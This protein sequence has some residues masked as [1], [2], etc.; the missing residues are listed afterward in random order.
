MTLTIHITL[1]ITL[2]RDAVAILFLMMELII[3]YFAMIILKHALNHT[4]LLFNIFLAT[5][6]AFKENVGLQT[7]LA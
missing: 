2:S 4:M 7:Y 5:K 3:N 1:E 6:P